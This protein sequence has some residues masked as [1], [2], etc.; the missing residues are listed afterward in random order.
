MLNIY[1]Y[2]IIYL[3]RRHLCFS[4]PVDIITTYIT[5]LGIPIEI[6]TF[7]FTSTEWVVII[8]LVVLYFYF[9]IWV[10]IKQYIVQRHWD[11]HPNAAGL[12]HWAISTFDI[13]YKLV[14]IWEH[15]IFLVVYKKS[16]N[17]YIILHKFTIDF[18]IF[19]KICKIYSSAWLSPVV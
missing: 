11:G 10:H 12:K 5:C 15:I 18:G 8:N 3:H 7:H 2:Y 1:Y 13:F 6:Y 4:Y 19:S 9:L 14:I 16:S 17:L